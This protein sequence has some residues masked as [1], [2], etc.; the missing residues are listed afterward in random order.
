MLLLT[1]SSAALPG[2][3]ILCG[4]DGVG[5]KKTNTGLPFHGEAAMIDDTFVTGKGTGLSGEHPFVDHFRY[6]KALEDEKTIAKQTIPA[7]LRRWHNSGCPLPEN[8]Q[9]PFTVLPSR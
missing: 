2:I 1:A 3:W 4:F 7:L 9:R 8:T 6:V 5:H